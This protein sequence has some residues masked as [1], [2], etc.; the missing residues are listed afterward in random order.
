MSINLI[1][2]FF[3]AGLAFGSWFLMAGLAFY[4][5]RTRVKKIDKIAHGFEIPH[6]SIFFLVMRVPNYGGAL[7]WQ[8]YAKRIGLAGKIEHFD[9]RFRWP[10]IA[11]FLLMLFGVLMLIAMVLF[12]HYAGIT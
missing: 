11:A 1:I 7:L 5:G 12:D 10:F 9:Q 3:L 8:W 2:S 4:A 6:D